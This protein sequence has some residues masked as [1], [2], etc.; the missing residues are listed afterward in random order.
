MTQ[1]GGREEGPVFFSGV[2][3]FDLLYRLRERRDER[4][5]VSQVALRHLKFRNQHTVFVHKHQAI[6]LFHSDAP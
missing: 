5:R 4:R 2:F 6:A 1:R 3:F